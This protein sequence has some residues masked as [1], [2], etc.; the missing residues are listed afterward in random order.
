MGFSLEIEFDKEEDSCECPKCG[1]ACESDDKFCCDC[2]AK[3]PAP[4]AAVASARKGALSKMASM[5]PEED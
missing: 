5:G 1:A 3:L 2:G 4:A